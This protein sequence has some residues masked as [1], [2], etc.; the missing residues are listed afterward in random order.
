VLAQAVW[1]TVGDERW[2]ARP[3]TRRVASETRVSLSSKAGASQGCVLP[4]CA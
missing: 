4:R 2:P 3:P 1:T